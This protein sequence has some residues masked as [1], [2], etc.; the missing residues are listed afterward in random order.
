MK[1]QEF[2]QINGYIFYLKFDDG[3]S[4]E[5]DL[6]NLLKNKISPEALAT[7]RIDKDWGCLEFLNSRVDIEP[8]TLY[9][10]VTSL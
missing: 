9:K 8:K 1:L 7:A 2:K 5:V 10:Y 4:K 3:L 6:E